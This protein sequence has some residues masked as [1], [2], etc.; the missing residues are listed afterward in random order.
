MQMAVTFRHLDT[1]EG[2]KSYVKEKVEKLQKYIENPQEV[3]VVLSAEK[4]RQTAE[5]TIVAD[6]MILNSQGKDSDLHVAIDQMVEKMERQI[7]E[8]REKSKRKRPN[9][10]LPRAAGLEAGASTEDQ[11]GAEI[12]VR[13]QRRP[14]FAKP[15]SP[16]EAVAQLNL[17]EQG[18]L[19]FI[20]SN[21]GQMNA[22][23]R[24]QDGGYEWVE[25]EPE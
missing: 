13:I 20:N 2:L 7:R 5:I 4:F 3:K 9:A 19:F 16:E 18:I 11:E 14:V 17:S 8:R 15:L 12:P 21:S 24:T 6:G 10:L 25:P 22:L 23:H 1:D